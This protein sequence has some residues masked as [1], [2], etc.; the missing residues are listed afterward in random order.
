MLARSLVREGASGASASGAHARLAPAGLSGVVLAASVL[1]CSSPELDGVVFAC[2]TNSDCLAGRVCGEHDGVRACVPADQSP[3]SIGMTGP[4]R[5]PSGELG[6][7]LRRGILAE[8]ARVNAEGGVS[9]RRLELQSKNDDY[10]PELALEAV[11]SLLDIRELAPRAGMPDVRGPG[12]VFAL[13]G[14][15]GTAST[16]ATAPLANRNGVVLFSPFTGA[17]DYL[18]DG[19][20]APYI[21]NFRPGYFD[22]TEVLVDY[23]ASQ[24]QPRIIASPA[25]DSYRRLLVFAQNDSYGDAGY[26]GI[27]EAYNRRAPL[28]QPDAGSPNPS[29][30]RIG[31]DRE[32]MASVEPAIAEASAFLAALLDDE[33]AGAPPISVGIVMVDTYQP[34]NQFIRAVKDWI[35][36]DAARASRLDVLFSQLSFVGA[37]ALAALLSSPPADYADVLDPT[38]R[39]SYADGVLVTQVVPSYDSEALGIAAYRR[40]IDR[41]DGGDYGFTSLEGYLT[42]RLFTEALALCPE[43]STEALRTTLDTALTDVDLGIGVKVGFSSVDHQASHTVWGSILR[44]DGELDVPFVWTPDSGIRPN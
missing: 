17:H 7:E 5:G 13:L 21:Y 25:G 35:N 11:E 39:R 3:I 22:E 10:D 23:M 44:A 42:A 41:F 26:A 29:I 38:R 6:V 27:V 8:F 31:Y 12:G 43:L 19:T 32:D 9:G 2:Q 1:S 30:A 37:D 40:D 15:I 28:P 14:N 36:A 16:L 18:R 33:S 4:F 20:R 34:A 24:R